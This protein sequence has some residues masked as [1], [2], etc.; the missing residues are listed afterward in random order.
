M[1]KGYNFLG[2]SINTGIHLSI[3][4]LDFPKRQ[5]VQWDPVVINN[6]CMV[7]KRYTFVLTEGGS[8]IQ[9]QAQFQQLGL[10][11]ANRGLGYPLLP[12]IQLQCCQLELVLSREFSSHQNVN[13]GA[14]CPLVG[15]QAR[16]FRCKEFNIP[17]QRRVQMK[18]LKAASISLEP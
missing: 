2:Q 3:A 10:V 8:H 13:F 12:T 15:N 4:V 9:R 5:P 16:K 14:V 17:N 7:S 18:I 11:I 6:R 1:L